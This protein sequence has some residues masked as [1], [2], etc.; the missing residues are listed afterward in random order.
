MFHAIVDAAEHDVGDG[1]VAEHDAGDDA[2]D[3]GDGDDDDDDD[4]DTLREET[5]TNI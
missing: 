4:D 2:D 5:M 1:L 3:V